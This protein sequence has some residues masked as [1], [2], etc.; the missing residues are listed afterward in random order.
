M[1]VESFKRGVKYI[2]IDS[3]WMYQWKVFNLLAQLIAGRVLATGFAGVVIFVLTC[4]ILNNHTKK[5]SNEILYNSFILDIFIV[6]LQVHY[7][8]EALLTAALIL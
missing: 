7:Y 3:K 4:G 8:S 1:K 5:Q 2:K 6:P